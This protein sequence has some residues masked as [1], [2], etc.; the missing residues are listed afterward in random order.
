[1]KTR[2]NPELLQGLEMF[3]DLDLRP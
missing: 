3:P 1:M 2:V